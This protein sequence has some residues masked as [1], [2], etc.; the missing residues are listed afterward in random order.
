MKKYENDLARSKS[1]REKQNKDLSKQ[2]EKLKNHHEKEVILFDHLM[3]LIY[4]FNCFCL[5]QIQKIRN[6]FNQKENQIK[7][8]FEDEKRVM[9]K[10]NS[11]CI[12]SVHD[13][14]LEN[15]IKYQNRIESL[16]A[17]ID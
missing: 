11:E 8:E 1:L 6:E 4:Y 15:N 17:V 14:N 13:K 9:L 12:T 3:R 10:K 7:Q 5:F 16:S 2:I